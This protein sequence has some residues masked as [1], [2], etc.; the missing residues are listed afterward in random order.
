MDAQ[1]LRQ[2]NAD[3]F[4]QVVQ[5]LRDLVAIP[6]VSSQL[7]HVADMERSADF[8]AKRFR[9]IGMTTRVV[10]ATDK[11]TLEISRPALL[12]EKA[13]P[14]GA[15]TVLLYAHHDVQ[16]EGDVAKWNSPPFEATER[17]GR[18]YGRGASDDGAGIAVHFAALKNWADDLPVTV[19]LFIEGEEEA[20]SPVFRAFLEEN[21]DFMK[22]DVI[23]VADSSNWDVHHPAI[24]VGLRGVLGLDVTVKTLNHA[25]HS[26]AFG[27]V[28]MDAPTALAR[29]IAT[30]H[31]DTGAV[32]VRGLKSCRSATVD[33]PEAELRKQ[34]GA[35][36][37]LELI[38]RGDLASRLWTQPAIAVIGTDVPS[39]E[40]A[41]NTIFPEATGRLSMR[42]AP[43]QNPRQAMDALK[44]HLLE[45]AP[46]GAEL[47][48]KELE[49]G[50]A[51][52]AD[53]ESD[54]IQLM[55]QALS[56]AFGVE[57][58]NIGLGGSI[59]FIVTF[60]E[61]IPEAQIL[62]TGVEDPYSNAHS[63]NESVNLSDLRSAALAET[64][65]FGH[66]AAQGQ[67]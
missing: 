25:V 38:G 54:A 56:E 22:A 8:L 21:L 55:H 39:L 37:G 20:G 43:G 31:D 12:A 13:G 34:V 47:H 61:L 7:G 2:T 33:Y 58:V 17:D 57:S 44:K 49:L 36:E 10:T 53:T 50:P 23:I 29:L 46:F 65:F 60:H 40:N 3:N 67:E 24:T 9:D 1:R 14:A 64:L 32:A 35:V 26:G 51:Y 45:N 28:V 42:I 16:P 66:F 4:D 18:L 27:G 63:E 59:P 19:K 41:S 30:L 15:P 5:L 62:V 11:Q 6:S 52:S 48:F